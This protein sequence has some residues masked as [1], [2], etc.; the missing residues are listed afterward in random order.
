MEP[1]HAALLDQAVVALDGD[2]GLHATLA[3]EFQIL[4]T[5][6]GTSRLVASRMQTY[7][8]SA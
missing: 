7:S 6:R 5:C 1:R 4:D 8:L 2:G 3:L